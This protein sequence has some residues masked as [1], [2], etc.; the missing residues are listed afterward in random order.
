[1][2]RHLGVKSQGG[3]MRSSGG[4]GVGMERE[5][6]CMYVMGTYSKRERHTMSEQ[7]L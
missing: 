5:R 3:L 2:V 1:M 6:E 7:R 4:G